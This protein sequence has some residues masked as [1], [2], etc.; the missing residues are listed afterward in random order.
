MYGLSFE[1]PVKNDNLFILSGTVLYGN[2]G[3][4]LRGVFASAPAYL[5]IGVSY[6][7]QQAN[8]YAV[9]PGNRVY[10]LER[11]GIVIGYR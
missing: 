7:N 3:G 4:A 6:V 5:G 1:A 10:E 2:S 9:A 8:D 11:E